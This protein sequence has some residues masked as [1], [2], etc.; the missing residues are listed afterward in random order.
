MDLLPLTSSSSVTCSLKNDS[1]GL[2]TELEVNGRRGW[3]G[4]LTR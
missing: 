3:V 2:P 1:N 4:T